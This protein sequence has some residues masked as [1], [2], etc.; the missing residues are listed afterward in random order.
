MN[1]T[2]SIIKLQKYIKN[3]NTIKILIGKIHKNI[4]GIKQMNTVK[5]EKNEINIAPRPRYTSSTADT[6]NI[7]TPNTTKD[8]TPPIK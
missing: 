6:Q 7:E 3:I 1:K 5:G 2:T 8:I 4:K